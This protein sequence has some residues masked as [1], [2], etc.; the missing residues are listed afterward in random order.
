[1]K[2][3]FLTVNKSYKQ[4]QFYLNSILRLGSCP[5]IFFFSKILLKLFEA[6]ETETTQPLHTTENSISDSSH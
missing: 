5:G 4:F 1:M 6:S 2:Q 3:L